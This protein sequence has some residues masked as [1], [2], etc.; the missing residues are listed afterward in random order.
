MQVTQENEGHRKFR[1]ITD[2]FGG[3]F[4]ECSLRYIKHGK[5]LFYKNF[6][7]SCAIGRHYIHTNRKPHGIAGFHGGA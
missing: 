1:K 5:A 7:R 4:T 2:A 6:Q 3:P